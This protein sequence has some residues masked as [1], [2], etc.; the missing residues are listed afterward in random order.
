ML[1][2]SI[3]NIDTGIPEK[4]PDPGKTKVRK[5]AEGLI[6]WGLKPCYHEP[7]PYVFDIKS[8]E[9]LGPLPECGPDERMIMFDGMVRS[10]PTLV[11][12]IRRTDRVKDLIAIYMRVLFE[13]FGKAAE[14]FGDIYFSREPFRS[15]PIGEPNSL[16]SLQHTEIIFP[17]WYRIGGPT[18]LWRNQF[19][20]GISGAQECQ[21][22]GKQKHFG[23]DGGKRNK[24]IEILTGTG[25]MFFCKSCEPTAEEFRRL[26]C[27]S[28]GMYNFPICKIFE[29]HIMLAICP[30]DVVSVNT[31]ILKQVIG[32]N[33]VT[34][35]SKLVEQLGEIVDKTSQEVDPHIGKPSVNI[36]CTQILKQVTG[37]DA[38]TGESKLV[39]QSENKP[40]ARIGCQFRQCHHC[41]TE[42]SDD[43]KFCKR[44][45][46]TYYCGRDCQKADWPAHKLICKEH[47]DP[48]QEPVS[49]ED[50]IRYN[51]PVE[52]PAR[53]DLS[54]SSPETPIE[55][56]AGREPEKE[57]SIEE[58]KNPRGNGAPSQE[59]ASQSPSQEGS[60]P[61]QERSP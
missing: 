38:V 20:I 53:S 26:A 3:L 35:E 11:A 22:C 60:P 21:K 8:V 51:I 55:K 59:G 31:Q 49:I 18:R 1:I 27:R 14:Q 32:N 46:R 7:G 10:A 56:V 15:I 42:V 44:C 48:W 24:M 34:G 19:E 57:N 23:I 54:G 40:S 37:N 41:P 33:A 4:F 29:P 61:S 13:K 16:V 17:V 12:V 52:A 25:I 6:L 9:K 47:I 5:M 2:D 45:L 43:P 30:K 28:C 50:Y 36:G 39:E 58:K